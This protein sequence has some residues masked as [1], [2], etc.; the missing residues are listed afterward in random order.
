M[1]QLRERFVGARQHARVVKDF[2]PEPRVQQVQ[3]SVLRAAHVQI[4]RQPR[5]FDQGIDHRVGVLRVGEAEVVPTGPRPLRHRVRFARV[6]KAVLREEAPVLRASEAPARVRPRR[7]VLHLRQLQRQFRQG[8]RNGPLVVDFVLFFVVVAFGHVRVR[9]FVDDRKINRDGLAPVPLAREDP[10]AEFVRGGGV[11]GVSF[12]KQVHDARLGVLDGKACEEV[13]A[14]DGQGGVLVA[15]RQ[16]SFGCCEDDLRDVEAVLGGKVE[17]ARVVRRH[18]HD[19]ARAVA[20]EHVVRDPDRQLFLG[21][22]MFAVEPREDAGLRGERR[23]FEIRF[24]FRCL[25]VRSGLF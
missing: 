25:H 12:A 8:H 6:Q 16:F 9:A 15:E 2:V 7:V 11:A 1:N 20:A 4:D 10:V 21:E 19:R 17:V 13:A 18:G 22:R 3:H 23:A 5:L 14:L 24:R